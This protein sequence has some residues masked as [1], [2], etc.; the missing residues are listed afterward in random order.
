MDVNE[1]LEINSAGRPWLNI[2]KKWYIYLVNAKSSN[3]TASSWSVAWRVFARTVK[4]G[5]TDL[6]SQI[7]DQVFVWKIPWLLFL[8][9]RTLG[10]ESSG[11]WLLSW[12]SCWED[13]QLIGDVCRAWDVGRNPLSKCNSSDV[14]RCLIWWFRK[15]EERCWVSTPCMVRQWELSLLLHRSYTAS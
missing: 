8:F 3:Q 9:P 12:P 2:I 1:C 11:G 4:A 13:R 15:P 7:W 14:W 5:S 6:L 10:G